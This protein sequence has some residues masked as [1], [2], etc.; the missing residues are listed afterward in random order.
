MD[1]I[2]AKYPINRVQ[3]TKHAAPKRLSKLYH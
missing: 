2:M 1:Y 3:I